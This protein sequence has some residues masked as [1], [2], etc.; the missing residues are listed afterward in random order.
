MGLP[1]TVERASEEAARGWSRAPTTMGVEGCY[2]A[3]VG[4]QPPAAKSWTY[5]SSAARI[6]STASVAA[7]LVMR[8][9]VEMR[10]EI[11]TS[12]PRPQSDTT[13]VTLS[14]PIILFTIVTNG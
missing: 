5:C 7:L 9:E 4:R 10:R 6:R 3:A 2:S 12:A 11:P 1:P 8:C 13:I 14:Q